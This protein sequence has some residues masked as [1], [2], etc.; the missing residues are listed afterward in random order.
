MVHRPYIKY[1]F[2]RAEFG[3]YNIVMTYSPNY[4]KLMD[5]ETTLGAFDYYRL[6]PSISLIAALFASA[7]GFITVRGSFHRRK[8]SSI[9]VVKSTL[10]WI[11]SAID[12]VR[13]PIDFLKDCKY[14][15]YF[16]CT[17]RIF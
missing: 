7:M 2:T 1:T 13:A 15:P 9:P 8:A 12:F 5:S 16:T 3:I 11:G 17:P 10:P 6:L 14:V 4:T